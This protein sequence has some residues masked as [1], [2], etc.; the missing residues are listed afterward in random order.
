MGMFSNLIFV[1]ISLIQPIAVGVGIQVTDEIPS[2]TGR[3]DGHSALEVGHVAN[4]SR[5]CRSSSRHRAHD[6]F[7][8][9]SLCQLRCVG[10]L[11][12]AAHGNTSFKPSDCRRAAGRASSCRAIGR[13]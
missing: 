9:M 10:G 12:H 2:D 4:K 1:V 3:A 7:R 5:G 11:G 13:I 6:L 8:I